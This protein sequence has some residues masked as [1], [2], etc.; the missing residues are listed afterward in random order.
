MISTTMIRWWLCA[1]EWSRSMASVAIPRAVEN[2]NEVSVC[3]MSL[4]MVLG[5]WMTFIPALDRR[6][7]VFAVPPPPMHTRASRPSFS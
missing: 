4:S 6:L 7:A 5:R 1:V 2:P 3:A